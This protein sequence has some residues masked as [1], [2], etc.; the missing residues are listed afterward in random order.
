MSKA[1]TWAPEKLNN[2]Q[3]SLGVKGGNHSEEKL[4]SLEYERAVRDM[5]EEEE[6]DYFKG[7]YGRDLFGAWDNAGGGDDAGS[8]TNGK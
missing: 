2:L 7:R 6:W 4:D 3:T 5:T 8:E 1:K